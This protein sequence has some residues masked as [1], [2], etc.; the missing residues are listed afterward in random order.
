MEGSTSTLEYF[1]KSMLDILASL[2]GVVCMIVQ[3]CV[4]DCTTFITH[5]GRFYFNRLPFGITSTL[6]YFQKSM[7]DILAGLEGV[8]CMIVDVMI[9]DSTQDEHDR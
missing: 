1:Q 4:H 8:V 5:F 2:E 9:H 3:H 7:S 6:E